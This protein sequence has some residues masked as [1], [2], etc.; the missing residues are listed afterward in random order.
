MKIKNITVLGSGIMGHGIAQ[1]A[2]MSGYEVILRDIDKKFLDKAMD[3]IKWSLKKL[4]EKHKLTKQEFENIYKKIIPTTDLNNAVKKCDLIIEAVPEMMNLKQKVYSELEKITDNHVIFASNT[5]TLPITEISEIT[6]RSDKVIGIH[7]FN[8]PQLMKLVEIIPGNKTDTNITKTITDFVLSLGKH[9]ILCKKDVPGFIVNRLFIPMIHEACHVIE[10][11]KSSVLEVDSAVKFNL[12]FPMGVFE[13]A[14]FTGL[15]VIHK[16]TSEMQS[17]DKKI[18]NK[19]TRI[20]N[21]FQKNYLGRKTGKGFYEYDQNKYTRIKLSEK[22]AKNCNVIQIIANILNN[23]SWLV[24]NKVSNIEEIETAIKLGL[25]V[26]TP[27]LQ[28][29]KQYGIKNIIN[30]LNKLCSK[31]GDIY[32]PDPF[33]HKLS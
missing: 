20:E 18:I 23:M 6:D 33:L 21:L 24:T 2:A 25:G 27:I 31:Y 7:F 4:V 26:K 32:K 16:A 29:A 5:S 22:L 11:Q 3:N 28:T 1:V 10:R 13:L 12:N 17:R 14:D 30:E 19:N 9:P 8:P 15:D